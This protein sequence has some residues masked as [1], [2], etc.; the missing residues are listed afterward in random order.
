MH[1]FLRDAPRQMQGMAESVARADADAVQLSAHNLKGT[2]S[3]V[4]AAELEALCA[5]IEHTSGKGLLPDEATMTSVRAALQ[6]AMAA[7]ESEMIRRSHR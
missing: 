1:L 7:L 5:R 6:S 4:G 3:T 2:S